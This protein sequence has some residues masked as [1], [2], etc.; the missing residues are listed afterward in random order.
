[1]ARL[2]DTS[3]LLPVFYGHSLSLTLK[4]AVTQQMSADADQQ[5]QLFEELALMR[6]YA[7]RFV[8]LYA[9]AVETG[10]EAKIML[11]GE[12]MREAL[13][14]VAQMCERAHKIREKQKDR[15]S[16]HD[17]DHIVDQ[18]VV[19]HHEV[20]DDYQARTKAGLTNGDYLEM[21]AKFEEAVREGLVM[22]NA[23]VKGTTLHPDQ[24]AAMFDATVPS[25]DDDQKLTDSLIDQMRETHQDL[26]SVLKMEGPTNA[27]AEA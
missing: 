15:F 11:A 14:S 6:V 7:S 21:A 18:I 2:R 13:E 10:N 17:V 16:M 23:A 9:A 12:T 5:T 26:R 25:L 1:M 20:A 22:P 8:A 4:E 27:D 19:I 3:K 24:T